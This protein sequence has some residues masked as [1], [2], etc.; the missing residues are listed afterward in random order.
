MMMLALAWITAASALSHEKITKGEFNSESK[1][2]WVFMD[3]Y[4]GW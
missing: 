3:M 2:K 1:G 4:A